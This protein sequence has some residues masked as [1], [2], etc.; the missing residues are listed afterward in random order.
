[1][2][3]V[4][5]ILHLH[6]QTR[7]CA[8]ETFETRRVIKSGSEQQKFELGLAC[9][10]REIIQFLMRIQEGDEALTLKTKAKGQ[11]PGILCGQSDIQKLLFFFF[12]M[13]V[14][15]I[16]VFILKRGCSVFPPPHAW[17]SKDLVYL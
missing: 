16:F 4:L 17:C 6:F 11:N 9:V 12:L 5:S 15:S 10:F 2:A 14:C 7:N 13:Y 3:N 8:S 1:M